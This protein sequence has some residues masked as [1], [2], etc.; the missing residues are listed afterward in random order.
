VITFSYGVITSGI[1]LRWAASEDRPGVNLLIDLSDEAVQRIREQVAAVKQ[2]GDIVVL[3]IHWGSNWGYTIPRTQRTFAH[4]LIEEAGVDIIHGHSSHHV[5]GIEVYKDRLIIYGAGDFINDYEGIAGYEEF[6]GDLALMYF[7]SVDPATGKLV[8]LQ[9][10]P[11]QIR[12]FRLNRASRADALWLRDV[13]NRE[14]RTL[15]TRVE[16][17]GDGVLILGWD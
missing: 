12:H 5:K 15:G 11:M 10:T 6:R 13:L 7:A 2:P 9:M 16:M 1:P 8:R 3:S 14:G 17:D 4:R